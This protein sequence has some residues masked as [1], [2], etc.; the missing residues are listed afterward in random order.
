[1]FPKQLFFYTSNQL[2]PAKNINTIFCIIIPPLE[3]RKDEKGRKRKE[4][5]INSKLMV[6]GISKG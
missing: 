2:F 1:M 6:I 4:N 5:K 3:T